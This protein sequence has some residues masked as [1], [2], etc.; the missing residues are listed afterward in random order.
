MISRC[1]P[2]S[3]HRKPIHHPANVGSSFFAGTPTTN[4]VNIQ[5][6]DVNAKYGLGKTTNLHCIAIL[7]ATLHYEDIAK[8]IIEIYQECTSKTHGLRIIIKK[9]WFSDLEILEIHLKTNNEQ[10][11][12]T[13]SDTLCFDKQEKSNRN[14]PPTSEHR[15]T[16]PPTTQS[17]QKVNL[18]NL[19]RIM[20]EPK[21]YLATTKKHRME[22]NQDGNGKINQV[23]SYIRTKNITKLNEL[24][25]A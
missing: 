19:K 8:G 6:R 10:D 17:K 22:N 7:G 5:I 23:L 3:Q 20:N 12:N 2:D 15:N 4:Q 13:V 14:E 24:I 21:N 9:G 25:Y 18:E 11:T 16:T 1:S